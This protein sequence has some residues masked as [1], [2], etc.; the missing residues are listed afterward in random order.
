MTPALKA[1]CSNYTNSTNGYDREISRVANG[2]LDGSKVHP[3]IGTSF[4]HAIGL[5]EQSDFL[6]TETAPLVTGNC[7]TLRFGCDD[8]ERDTSLV[9]AMIQITD[10]GNSVIGRLD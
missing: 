8:G 4:G 3:V 10:N 7:Y 5:A 6:I 2:F 9:S 1:R